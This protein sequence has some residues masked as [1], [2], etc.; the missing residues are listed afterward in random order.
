MSTGADTALRTHRGTVTL[1]TLGASFLE[2]TYV[3]ALAEAKVQNQC[4]AVA[5]A[6][7]VK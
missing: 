6:F 4:K 7:K 5:V 3:K 1:H 2:I